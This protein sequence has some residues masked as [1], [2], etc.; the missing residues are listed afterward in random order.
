MC[1]NTLPPEAVAAVAIIDALSRLS[2]QKRAAWLLAVAKQEVAADSSAREDAS[3]ER[4]VAYG[5]RMGALDAVYTAREV[6]Y[7]HFPSVRLSPVEV[8][9]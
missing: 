2:V 4:R 1:D 3:R 6:F 7:Q 5:E 8:T 9:A